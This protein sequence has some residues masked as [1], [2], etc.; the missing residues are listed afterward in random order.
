VKSAT[1]GVMAEQLGI[2]IARRLGSP[3]VLQQMI[4]RDKP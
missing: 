2:E 4:L 1:Q 3:A